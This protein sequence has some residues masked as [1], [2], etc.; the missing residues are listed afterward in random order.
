MTG[1]SFDPEFCFVRISPGETLIKQGDDGDCL[2][3][4]EKGEVD[5]FKLIVSSMNPR[6]PK[7]FSSNDFSC[8]L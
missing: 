8:S 5:V 3:L 1:C 2:Y 4:I 6:R 7:D